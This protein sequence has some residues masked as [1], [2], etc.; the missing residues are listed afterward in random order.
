MGA[1]LEHA[2]DFPAINHTLAEDRHTGGQSPNPLWSGTRDAWQRFSRWRRGRP[3]TGAVLII[4]AAALVLYSPLALLRFM[5]LPG[6][7]LWSALLVGLLLLAMGVIQ[8]FAP[9][10]ALV[11]GAVALVLSLVSLLVALGGLGFGMLL[12]LAGGALGIAWRMG[13]NNAG[14]TNRRIFGITYGTSLAVLALLVFL[15]AQG[16]IAL[17]A[18]I[19]VPFSI[20][21]DAINASSMH[22]YPGVSAA[23]NTSPVGVV[24]MNA[25]A[26]NMVISKTFASPIGNVTLSMVAGKTT[27]VTLNGLTLDASSL[28]SDSAAFQNLSINAAGNGFDV[29]AGTTNLS[30]VNIN[31]PYVLI[32]SITLPG[33]SISL[34]R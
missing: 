16:A 26:R 3:F 27:P 22:L 23:D 25:T 15:A 18:E 8:L 11:T 19:A 13:E 20:H 6:S 34:S 9:A 32:N 2:D 30:N 21:S 7:M 28:A 31:S 24:Q 33:L 4:I 14:R 1:N 17:A 5:F 29:H 12:G 10:H